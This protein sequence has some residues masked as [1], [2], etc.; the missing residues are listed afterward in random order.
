M[1]C[2]AAV[3]VSCPFRL[4]CNMGVSMVWGGLR[5]SLSSLCGCE[6]RG[7]GVWDMLGVPPIL[8]GPATATAQL[9]AAAAQ[10]T[11]L[12]SHAPHGVSCGAWPACPLSGRTGSLHACMQ[13]PLHQEHSSGSQDDADAERLRGMIAELRAQLKVR[14]PAAA[15]GTS[16]APTQPDR[17]L[18]ADGPLP[19]STRQ[20]HPWHAHV[21]HPSAPV[22]AWCAVQA[23]DEELWAA[24]LGADFVR[25]RKAQQAAS[26]PPDSPAA[27]AELPALGGAAASP[28]ITPSP[29]LGSALTPRFSRRLVARSQALQSPAATLGGL[30]TVQVSPG[31]LVAL[32]VSRWPIRPP[33]SAI[34]HSRKLEVCR[35]RGLAGGSGG[36]GAG[37]AVAAL[38]AVAPPAAHQAAGAA[39][40]GAVAGA[41]GLA[42][43][44]SRVSSVRVQ[45]APRPPLPLQDIAAMCSRGDP[46]LAANLGSD[47][48]VSSQ[49]RLRALG[50]QTLQP[51]TAWGFTDEAV[52]ASDDGNVGNLAHRMIPHVR[53]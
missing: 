53:L 23:K 27:S 14:L 26:Q 51:Q 30:S 34:E 52:Q 25:Q 40:T 46:A 17:Q 19:G 33:R 48:R 31:R 7:H 11:G 1:R 47:S 38:A 22:P 24:R 32:E 43:P 37:S 13:T 8:S 10:R 3:C 18:P 28:G 4:S 21:V 6:R 42:A 2:P 16:R 41:V 44:A 39:A 45:R 20:V 9:V 50:T 5:V 15:R 12:I 49:L 36:C 35:L 29:P